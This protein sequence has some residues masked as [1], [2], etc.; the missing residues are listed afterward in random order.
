MPQS[1]QLSRRTEIRHVPDAKIVQLAH[2]L[3]TLNHWKNLMRSIPALQ[4]N[5]EE[6]GGTG[7]KYNSSDIQ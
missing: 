5:A 2:I 1:L 4:I 6:F 7:Y 3:N